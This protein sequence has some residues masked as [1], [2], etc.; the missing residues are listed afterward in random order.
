MGAERR[1]V[2]AGAS[3]ANRSRFHHNAQA[4]DL[5]ARDAAARC[6]MRLHQQL[7]EACGVITEYV[8]LIR[9]PAGGRTPGSSAARVPA[10]VQ[11]RLSA[12]APALA[13]HTK[14]LLVSH[15]V[16]SRTH[17]PLESTAAVRRGGDTVRAVRGRMAATAHTSRGWV[18]RSYATVAWHALS[19]A[20]ACAF[21]DVAG[22]AAHAPP[23]AEVPVPCVEAVHSTL[24]VVL[25]LVVDVVAMHPGSWLPALDE[26]ARGY[27]RVIGSDA[28]PPTAL[29]DVEVDSPL[30]SVVVLWHRVVRLTEGSGGGGG[31]LAAAPQASG[32]GATAGAGLGWRM[33][34]QAV[35]AAVTG[36]DVLVPGA[37]GG[38]G[39]GDANAAAAAAF[40]D[41]SVQ[42]AWDVLYGVARLAQWS[43]TSFSC[44]TDLSG[45]YV[46]IAA[47]PPPPPPPPSAHA[48]RCT[49]ALP[50]RTGL[51]IWNPHST[52]VPLPIVSHHITQVQPWH[53]V[54]GTQLGS[55][56]TPGVRYW[57]V[58]GRGS[59]PPTARTVHPRR[60][61]PCSRA[62]RRVGLGSW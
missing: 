34:N 6:A 43:D 39:A 20:S 51:L 4:R 7:D 22:D 21:G 41:T 37:G 31:E 18:L 33:V 2:E 35:A 59:R 19:W 46:P 25:R 62:R 12:L 58:L 45:R 44:E 15:C 56:A 52:L 55:R 16:P 30:G 11:N 38:G 50:H 9:H 61:A 57:R 53:A 32:R 28:P 8:R 48:L 10:R 13:R 42:F 36:V 14:R 23:A 1:W 40:P 29:M 47:C 24:R 17:L 27:G 49:R 5:A 26:V 60:R 3:A 54:A